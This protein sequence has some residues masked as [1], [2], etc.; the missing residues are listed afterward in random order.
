MTNLSVNV[1]KVAWLRNAREGTTPDLIDLSS[2]I[3]LAGAAG[4]TVHPRP[5]LRHIR[6]AD[7]KD[8]RLLTKDLS[9]E[10]NVEGNPLSGKS[11]SYP[12][13][14]ELVRETLPDQC[15]FV[16]DAEHQLTSDHGWNLLNKNSNL[17]ECIDEANQLGIR[18][19]LFVDPDKKHLESAKELGASRVELYTGPY[20]D[21]FSNKDSVGKILNSYLTG[22]D[23]CRSINLG[24]NAGHDL[25]L[26]NLILFL[27]SVEVDEVSIGQALIADSLIYGLED[28]VSRYL[29]IC[30]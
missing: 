29:N 26:K 22:S 9:V 8:L 24:V 14:M 27:Q 23:Y 11:D 4:I 1:N 10:L 7:V 16:P 17:K 2:K 12:G 21:N 19:S 13:F 20:A 18:V 3:I 28:T 15:T 25:N 30:K 5:D 6:P